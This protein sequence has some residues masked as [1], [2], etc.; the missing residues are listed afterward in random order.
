M[1]RIYRSGPCLQFNDFESG[2]SGL[3]CHPDSAFNA[4]SNSVVQ[5]VG[6]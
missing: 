5:S 6:E 4:I 2:S 3:T 1:R